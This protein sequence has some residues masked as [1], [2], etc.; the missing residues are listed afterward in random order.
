MFTK[1]NLASTIITAIWGLGGG[2][3]LWAI[4]ADPYLTDHVVVPAVMK[5]EP[6]FLYLALGCLIQAFGF[7]TIYGKYGVGNYGANSGISMGLTVAIMIGLGE[8]LIDYATANIV[9]L[10]GTMVNF[11]VYIVFFAITG[12]L[13]G[14]VYQKM[15]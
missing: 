15:G 1:A 10:Q 11:L 12:L 6:E 2:F 14:I 3:L 13:A 9:D 7:S 8:K 4:L 5:A